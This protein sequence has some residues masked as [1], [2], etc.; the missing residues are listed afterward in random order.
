MR[1]ISAHVKN[2][3]IVPDEPIDL[4]DG[5]AVEVL[6]QSDSDDEMTIEGR[7]ELE[8]EIEAARDRAEAAPVQNVVALGV[9][10]EHAGPMPVH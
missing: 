10:D 5:V 1:S 6:V 3:L 4:Y 7:A 9:A 8:A 2:G